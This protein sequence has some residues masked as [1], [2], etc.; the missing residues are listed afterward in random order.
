MAARSI[1]IVKTQGKTSVS[2][3]EV[4]DMIRFWLSDISN[5]TW[6]LTL[7]RFS[8]PRTDAQRGLMWLWFTA[9][10]DEWSEAYGRVFTKENVHDDYCLKFLPITLPN[11]RNI[12]GETKHLNTEQ[13]SEFLNRVQADAQTEYGI[14]LPD[15]D[16]YNFALWAKMH[17][18]YQFFT[19]N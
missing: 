1:Q 9:I 16:D 10:A 13:M 8:K 7:T 14:Q 5:G 6:V 18:G 12:A 19:N 2:V 15:P 17:G 3:S 11:G 4:L